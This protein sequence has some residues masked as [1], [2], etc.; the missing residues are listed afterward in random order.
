M[1]TF[2][3]MSTILLSS[4]LY[5]SKNIIDQN[6]NAKFVPNLYYNELEVKHLK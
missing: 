5:F 6:C 3:F 4:I 1:M 2:E